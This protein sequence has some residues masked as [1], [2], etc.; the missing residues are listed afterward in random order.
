MRPKT[1]IG[2][3]F[4]GVFGFFVVTSFA[5]E[6]GGYE[7]FTQAE[8][9]GRRAHVVGTWVE[10]APMTYDAQ[11]NVFSFV[12]ADEEGVRRRVDYADPK[13]ANFEDAESVVVEGRMAGDAFAAEHILVK[14]P[15]KYNDGREF[16]AAEPGAAPATTA[17][18]QPSA[19]VTS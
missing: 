3:V 4:V 19:E 10:D 17:A 5:S 7:T 12:M 13:P 11:R 14:C 1:L 6:V 18:P 8:E 16:E 15:S 9:N 2:L